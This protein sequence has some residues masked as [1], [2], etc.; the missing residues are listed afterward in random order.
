V[1]ETSL[2]ARFQSRSA[3]I[4]IAVTPQFFISIIFADSCRDTSVTA[5]T[6]YINRATQVYSPPTEVSYYG[7]SPRAEIEH[8]GLQIF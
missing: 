7:F 5:P 3:Q 2:Q 8:N 6:N 4:L 1:I